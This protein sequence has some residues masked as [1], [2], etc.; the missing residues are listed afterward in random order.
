[1]TP[2]EQAQ[3][4]WTSLLALGPKRLALLGVIGLSTIGLVVF[5]G[6]YL[7]RPT[8]EVLYSGLAR[9]DVSSIGSALRE[10]GIPFD[11]SADGTSVLVPVG[12]TAQARMTLA[13]KGL[14]HSGSVGN[15]LF[16]KLGSLGLTSFMQEVTKV[17]AMEGELARTIQMMRG[18]KAARVHIVMGDEGSFRRQRQNPSASVVIRTE[19]SDDR[20]TAQAIRHLVA[21]AIPGMTVEEVTVLNVDGML[22]ASGSDSIDAEPS[23]MLSL[24]RSVSQDIQD[25]VR[26]TLAPYLSLRNFQ[27]SVAARLNTDKKQVNE[28]TYDPESRV[29][30]SVRIVKENTTAQNTTPSTATGV[31]RNLPSAKP[32]ADGAKQSSDETKKNEELTNYE[33]SSKTVQTTSEGYLIEGLSVA[34]LVNRQGI[35][36]SLGEK[37]TPE[38]IDKQVKD[39]EQLVSSAAGL[40]KERGDTIK[41]SV[42][43][44][45]DSGKELEPVEG[46]TLTEQLMKQSGSLVSAGTV[47][48]VAVLLIWFGLRPATKALLAS[49]GGA[50]IAFLPETPP[51]P[52]DS[53][54]A[55]LLDS[56]PQGGVDSLG[57][58]GG[59]GSTSEEGE[60]EDILRNILAR[61]NKNNPQKQ[62][63]QLVDYDEAQAAAILKQWIRQGENA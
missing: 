29:E 53:D 38:Q 45:V 52:V 33:V 57:G 41:I 46:P 20:S 42:V 47:L 24:E 27:I 58:L 34:V 10:V 11:V 17:R 13:E 62:L 12:Q 1:M 23:N 18:V 26:K 37:A 59:P 2:L 61:R 32:T 35:V 51:P 22:L 48:L 15:E 54:F 49:S 56:F 19:S 3:R 36:A 4:V 25:S 28:T 40:R 8:T 7:S 30:R 60:G 43:D 63:E 44:F 21:S 5:G 31:E 39:I 55:S 50:P 6:F 14:P 9:E 16:D